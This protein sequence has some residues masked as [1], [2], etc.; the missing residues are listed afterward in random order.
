MRE[1]SR[2]SFEVLKSNLAP[3]MAIFS[4]VVRNPTFPESEFD[5]EKKRHLDALGQ[6]SKNAGAIAR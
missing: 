4:D 6:Q 2:L 3:A 1:S 5:R